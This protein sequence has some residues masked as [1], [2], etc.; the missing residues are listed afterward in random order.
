MTRD[1]FGS[2]IPWILVAVSGATVL[3][4]LFR[5]RAP[6]PSDRRSAWDSDVVAALRSQLVKQEDLY[7]DQVEFFVNFPEVI[8]TLAGAVTIDQVTA[9]MSRGITALLGSQRLGIFLAH[10]DKTLRLADGAGFSRKFRGSYSCPLKTPE[11]LPVL[12]YR[13]VSELSDHPGVAHF[14][15]PLTL[16][17]VLAAPMWYGQRLLGLLVISKPSIDPNMARRIFAMLADLTAVSL[18]AAGLVA[19]IR[20]KAERDGLTGLPNRGT[21]NDRVTLEIERCT[22]Y[23]SK[24]SLVMIDIDNFKHYNDANGHAAG[25]EALKKVASVIRRGLR[26]TD[27]AARYGG[28]EFTLV[29]QSSDHREGLRTAERVR[30]MV[31]G[32]EFAYGASQ[33]LGHVSISLGLAT[34]PDDARDAASLFKA[35]DEALYIAKESGRDRVV[36]HDANIDISGVDVD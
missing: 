25:D 7:R 11:L 16:S 24:F 29:L 1:L 14:L 33:P 27:F 5:R 8:K 3:V 36:V 15:A 22:A 20:K 32:A 4:L 18:H 13:S 31:A 17:P 9:A 21:L 28:E 23:N 34:F 30:R 12:K 6:E 19:E 2:I 35:A 10:S 26:R